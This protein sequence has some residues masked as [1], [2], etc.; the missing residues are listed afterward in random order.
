MKIVS[1]LMF[2]ILVFCSLKTVAS[3]ELNIYSHRQ[4]YLLQPFLDAYKNKIWSD[5]MELWKWSPG[6]IF[7]VSHI[8]QLVKIYK[9]QLILY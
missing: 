6:V 2:S 8:M 4:P 5:F 9:K 7:S 3:K 1:I